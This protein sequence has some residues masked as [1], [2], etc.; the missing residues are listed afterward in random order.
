[1]GSRRRISL[2]EMMAALV[3][4]AVLLAAI[5]TEFGLI[6]SILVAMFGPSFALA[7]LDKR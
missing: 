3:L 5:R 1:M 2:K 7:Y 6:P 4:L